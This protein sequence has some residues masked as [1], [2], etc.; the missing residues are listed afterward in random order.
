M[1]EVEVFARAQGYDLIIGD[2]VL[3]ATATVDVTAQ[4]LERLAA[5]SKSPS[6]NTAPRAP[7]QH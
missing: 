4:V 7:E 3:F 6:A 1:Q 5:S 2:G